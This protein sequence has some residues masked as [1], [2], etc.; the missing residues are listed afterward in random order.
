MYD[1]VPTWLNV[2]YIVSLSFVH[3]MVNPKLQRLQYI[4]YGPDVRCCVIK[5]KKIRGFECFCCIL[6]ALYQSP[7]LGV[8]AHF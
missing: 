4:C 1:S 3:Q 2:L 6:K 7:D 5:V 8:P